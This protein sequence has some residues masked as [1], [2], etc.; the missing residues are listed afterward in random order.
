MA[1]PVEVRARLAEANNALQSMQRAERNP[2]LA[3]GETEFRTNLVSFFALSQSCVTMVGFN[4]NKINSIINRW[5]S[6]DVKL[7][8]WFREARNEALKGGVS[9]LKIRFEQ[10]SEHEY[11]R[12]NPPPKP[13][14]T[15]Y[16]RQV[17]FPGAP[18]M[19]FRVNVYELEIDGVLRPATETCRL[20][21][22][23]VGRFLQEPDVFGP[24][25]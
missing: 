15:Y 7:F 5:T 22:D 2:K 25:F 21:L 1:T 14:P 9:I 17:N 13:H 20:Y 3:D 11:R 16:P 23:L 10:I 24:G 8:N 12:R 19:T 18:R 4:S 6:D